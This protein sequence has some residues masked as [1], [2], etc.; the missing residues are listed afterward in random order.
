MGLL[1]GL[2]G[3]GSTADIEQISQKLQG[4]LLA[5][6]KVQL[7]FKIIRDFFAFTECRLIIVDVQ[8]MTGRKTDSSL[9]VRSQSSLSR[10]PAL[11]TSMRNSRS[12]SL[13]RARPLSERWARRSTRV[14]S[15]KRLLQASFANMQRMRL[16]LMLLFLRRREL[17]LGGGSHLRAGRDHRRRY[18][19]DRAR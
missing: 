4:I 18:L 13:D 5:E 17:Y 19:L 11:L 6:E 12:G 9:I 7:A 15:S 2:M 14:A 8:G 16:A 1:D 3:H 10:R